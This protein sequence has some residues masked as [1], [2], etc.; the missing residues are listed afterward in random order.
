[1][2]PYGN[3]IYPERSDHMNFQIISAYDHTEDI[4]NLFK[5]YTDMLIE[6]DPV[7]A[8]YLD[9]QNYDDELKDLS[10]KYGEPHGRLYLA[11][12]DGKA[13]GCIALKR[14]DDKSCELKRLYVRPEFR[15]KKLGKILAQR[16]IKEAKKAGYQ[17]IYLDTLPFLTSAIKLYKELGF[18][19][20]KKYND[21][22][23]ENSIYMIKEI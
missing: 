20:T 10:A 1:M 22:P 5:E 3:E 17:S 13:A 12:C 21:S 8:R 16:I 7:F 9:M 15:G 23:M 11:L 18:I 14:N 6:G 4:K 19:E 2:L